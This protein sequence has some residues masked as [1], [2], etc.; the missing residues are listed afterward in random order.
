MGELVS[1]TEAAKRLSEPGNKLTRSSLSRYV[2][3][4]ADALSPVKQGRTTKIDFDVLEQ[5]RREN[6]NVEEA[7]AP[8]P[9]S[10]AA[11][12]EMSARRRKASAEAELKE[13]DLEQRLGTVC[14]VSEVRGA[15]REAVSILTSKEGQVVAELAEVMAAK[16]GVDAP[17]L[18]P[19]LKEM[20]RRLRIEFAVA[21]LER[22][23]VVTGTNDPTETRTKQ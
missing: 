18:R 14:P 1:I 10:P 7:A 3:R 19:H 5:H 12:I 2:T 11:D 6:V 16:L 4:Y 17:V 13:L 22:V 21:L 23:D 20:A 9:A 15:A 8:A